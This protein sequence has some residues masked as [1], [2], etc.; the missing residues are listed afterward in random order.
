MKALLSV[1][2]LALAAAASPVGAASPDHGPRAQ[3]GLPPG[4]TYVM[5]VLI[6]VDEP[7][8]P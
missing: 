8:G 4:C 3:T 1:A 7:I 5:G 6:C 2:I